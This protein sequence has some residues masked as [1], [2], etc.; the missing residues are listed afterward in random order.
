VKEPE[1]EPEPEPELKI[2]IGP[3]GT[4]VKFVFFFMAMVILGMDLFFGK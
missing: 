3:E 2:E 1:P 4:V